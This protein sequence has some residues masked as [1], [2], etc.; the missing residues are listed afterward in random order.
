MRSHYTFPLDLKEVNAAA[1]EYARKHYAT[2]P[3]YRERRR[4]ASAAFRAAHPEYGKAYRLK[5]RER[6]LA[7]RR[8]R[9]A[10]LKAVA[11]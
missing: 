11:A 6:I 7:T 10:R 4:K 2:D 9:Y 1:S 8:A 5:N 3:E